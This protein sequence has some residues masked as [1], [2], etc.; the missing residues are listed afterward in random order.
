M[1]NKRVKQEMTKQTKYWMYSGSFA[2]ALAMAMRVPYVWRFLFLL[3]L[4]CGLTFLIDEPIKPVLKKMVT[5]FLF[6]FFVGSLMGLIL[7]VLFG[8][9][10]MMSSH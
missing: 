5:V 9:F 3:I 6:L 2:Y 7:L 10:R 1:L 4:A 8:L